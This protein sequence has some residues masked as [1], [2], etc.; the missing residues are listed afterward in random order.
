[1]SEADSIAVTRRIWRE[2]VEDGDL[3]VVDDLV[4]DDYVYR[5]PGG[6][7]LHGPDGFRRYIGALHELFG[8]IELTLHEYIADGNRVLSRW[9]GRGRHRESGR[10]VT[11]RGATITL[12]EGGKMVDD[13]EYWDRLE[14]AEQLAT[15]WLQR[16]LVKTVAKQAQEK[17]PDG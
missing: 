8:E 15:G 12:V 13:W 9:T 4:A 1:M 7:E 11:W 16:L 3:S 2:I 5:G 6:L 14:L 10:K 17:L